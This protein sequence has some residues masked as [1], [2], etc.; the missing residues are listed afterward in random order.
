MAARDYPAASDNVSRLRALYGD[1][2]LIVLDEP[3]AN[4]DQPGVDALLQAV[5]HVKSRGGTVVLIAH[6]PNI[7]K[8]VDYLLVL[9]EGA[10]Q[11]AGTRDEVLAKVAPPRVTPTDGAG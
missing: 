10:V 5:G 1:P 11:L 2:A 6:Q 4:L 3:T 7:V 9:Q 8:L